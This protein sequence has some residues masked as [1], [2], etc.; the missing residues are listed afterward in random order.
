MTDSSGFDAHTH[1][2]ASFEDK[3][4]FSGEGEP[5]YNNLFYDSFMSDLLK[6]ST[7]LPCTE[8]NHSRPKATT[9]QDAATTQPPPPASTNTPPTPATDT[10]L[11]DKTQAPQSHEQTAYNELRDT[12]ENSQATPSNG[13]VLQPPPPHLHFD[14]SSS[15]PISD[16]QEAHHFVVSTSPKSPPGS[17]A[18][19]Q[20]VPHPAAAMH[21]QSQVVSSSPLLHTVQG[22]NSEAMPTSSQP[23]PGHP[24]RS[25]ASQVFPCPHEPMP[26]RSQVAYPPSGNTTMVPNLRSQAPSIVYP[27]GHLN[28]VTLPMP[29]FPIP[30]PT[31]STAACPQAHLV[32][33]H[34][35]NPNTSHDA[36]MPIHGPGSSTISH[37]QPPV[38]TMPDSSQPPSLNETPATAS[39]ALQPAAVA[40]HSQLPNTANAPSLA[41]RSMSG[42]MALDGGGVAL[43]A[44]PSAAE[45]IPPE[46][47]DWVEVSATE[48]SKAEGGEDG[49]R[50][51]KK[52]EGLG[53]AGTTV[54]VRLK[55]LPSLHGCLISDTSFQTRLYIDV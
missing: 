20:S 45:N 31:D 9:S 54:Q 25:L 50:A 52:K 44:T 24:D 41:E 53:P 39:T 1:A 46:L 23:F 21:E 34:S 36:K 14:T 38:A 11:T 8:R 51:D 37:T 3:H 35:V 43:G 19:N 55:E 5:D 28:G 12:T 32:S 10:T 27:P 18:A 22:F 48:D 42:A 16:S 30:R 4:V 15:K 2:L 13:T 17:A 26:M 40:A 47:P 29:H 33:Q 7:E 6:D 49:D